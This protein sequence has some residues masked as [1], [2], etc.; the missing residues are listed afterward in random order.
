L[1]GF[2]SLEANNENLR[3]LIKANNDN[4]KIED[5]KGIN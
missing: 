5:I 2:Q 3:N 1:E 4:Q